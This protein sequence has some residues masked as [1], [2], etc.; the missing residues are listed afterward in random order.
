MKRK[1]PAKAIA[2]SKQAEGKLR[3]TSYEIIYE[4]IKDTKLPR[5]INARLEDLHDMAFT[6]PRKAIEQLLALKENYPNVPVLYNFLAAAYSRVGNLKAMREMI[7]EN[8]QRNPDYLFARINYA[9]IS[10]QDGNIDQIPVIF[11]NKFDLEL[12]YPNR[13]RFHVT[14]FAGFTAII[15]AYFSLTGKHDRAEMLFKA[16]QKGAPGSE[17]IG[18]AKRYLYPSLLSRLRTL[19]TGKFPK[20]EPAATKPDS[21]ED[22]SK[23]E[24]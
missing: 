12:L 1:K 22:D 11:D 13:N 7:V 17:M 4:P 23:F 14:E 24:A 5:A 10:I 16:L 18:F 3:L 19:V 21:G 9:Q 15:C 20:K 2:K 8:Y 6:D